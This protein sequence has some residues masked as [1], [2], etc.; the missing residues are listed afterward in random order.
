M[1]YPISFDPWQ[2]V[3]AGLSPKEQLNLRYICARR[4]GPCVEIKA[5][6]I[7]DDIIWVTACPWGYGWGS[8]AGRAV[9]GIAGCIQHTVCARLTN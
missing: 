1:R 3:T 6:L 5:S 9:C 8:G 2:P 4:A 7:A